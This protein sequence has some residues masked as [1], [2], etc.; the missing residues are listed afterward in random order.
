MKRVTD[1][2]SEIAAASKEQ[3]TGIEQVNKAVAQMDR[4]TQSNASQTEE[5]A[6]TATTLLGH[7]QQLSEL[8]NRFR[9]GNESKESASHARS[10]SGASGKP[11]RA[12]KSSR[13]V[14]IPALDAGL[15]MTE[16]MEF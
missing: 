15:P 14:V 11:R 9:L 8:A 12:A 7:A 1:I 2:V 4:A 5:L 16:V 13:P 3:L 10:T 6:G